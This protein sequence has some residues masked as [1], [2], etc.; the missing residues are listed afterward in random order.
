MSSVSEHDHVGLIAKASI[1]INAPVARVWDAFVKP[2]IIKQ[3]MFNTNV[4]T[5][6]KEGSPILWK[7]LWQGKP[8]ED[9]GIILK[10]KPQQL[11]Q[12][13][14]YSPLTGQPDV[15]ENYHHVTVELA[16]E[17]QHTTVTL[18]QDGNANDEERQHSEEN[19]LM[20]LKGLKALLEKQ[21]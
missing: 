12:Y 17:G 3:Y 5:D 1:T 2:E 4:V 21:G 10:F 6:W 7:G 18:S 19:W 20:M 14:H 9:K 16:G 8:Y 13:S 11:I 15:P